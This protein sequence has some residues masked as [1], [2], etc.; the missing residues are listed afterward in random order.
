[1]ENE[2]NNNSNFFDKINNILK[3]KKF[4]L[5][6]VSILIVLSILSLNIVN[7]YKDNQNK[8]ISEQYIKAGI[9][10]SL[11]ELNNSKKAY[12]EIIFSKNKF[13]S[14]LAL[15]KIIE[16]EL[17]KN[18]EEILKLFDI[19]EEISHETEQKDL[20]KLK[21][22][23]YL[24]KFTDPQKGKDLLKEIVDSKSIWKDVALEILD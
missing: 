11:D 4:F 8:K 20:V 16:N 17:E 19:I 15:N 2:I 1:M 10:L 21:K 24:I 6:S 23:L 14:I 12:K 22:A 13:Y 7:L 3:K 18:P 5:I 9:F